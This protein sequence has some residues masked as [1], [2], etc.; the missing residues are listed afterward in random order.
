MARYVV[1]QELRLTA[2]F[3]NEA[4]ALADPTTV[5]F[6]VADNEGNVTE[7]ESPLQDSVG[8]YHQDILLTSGGGGWTC[9]AE[10][11][12]SVVGANE[13]SFSVLPTVFG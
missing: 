2:T 8:V 13:M 9:R 3:R 4:G 7:Y 6:K 1:N 10:G 12:G 5:I 11:T